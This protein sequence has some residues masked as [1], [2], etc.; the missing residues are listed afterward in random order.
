M[1]QQKPYRSFAVAGADDLSGL[2]LV[3]G[4]LWEKP[5][6]DLFLRESGWMNQIQQDRRKEISWF[7]HGMF[8]KPQ[9]ES[10]YDRLTGASG[11]VPGPVHFGD[12]RGKVLHREHVVDEDNRRID[13]MCILKGSM[14]P[15]M[16]CL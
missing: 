2:V 5:N 6:P 14:M 15:D 3:D 12:G 11:Q 9:P 7:V 16:P 4:L 1:A 8:K 13:R 10:Y